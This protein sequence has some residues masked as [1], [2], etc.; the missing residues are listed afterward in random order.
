MLDDYEGEYAVMMCLAQI[1]E[2]VNRINDTDI[3]NKIKAPG[4]VSFRNRLI[5]NYEGRDKKIILS[6]IENNLP[7]LKNTI[8]ALI[9]E[10]G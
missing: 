4:I 9:K 1:A 5:H 7:E 6:I 2:A 8:S 10:I 3:L